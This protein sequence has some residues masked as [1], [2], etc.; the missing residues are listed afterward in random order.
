[1]PEGEL[2]E[3]ELPEEELPEAEMPEED[4]PA[5]D[6]IESV[7]ED[8]SVKLQDDAEIKDY[9]NAFIETTDKEKIASIV[10]E[11]D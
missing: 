4:L 9:A 2:P 1:M 3:A 11:D 6:P 7:P 8:L 5:A 10:I